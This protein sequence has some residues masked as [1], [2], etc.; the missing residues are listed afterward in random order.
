MKLDQMLAECLDGCEWGQAATPI[1]DEIF[2]IGLPASVLDWPEWWRRIFEEASQV[3]K[4]LLPVC[5]FHAEAAAEIALR[6]VWANQH[7]DKSP[8]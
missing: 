3:T 6:C 4:R 1:N 7:G 5:E 2:E 8:S